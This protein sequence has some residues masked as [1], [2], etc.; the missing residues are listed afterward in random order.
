MVS[1]AVDRSAIPQAPA[2]SGGRSPAEGW[3]SVILHAAL[4][5]VMAGAIGRVDQRER[6]AIL[7][8]L[9]LAGGAAG[10][11]LA[12]T[13]PVDLLAHLTTF[14][15]GV[16]AALGLTAVRCG[17]VGGGWRQSLHRLDLRAERLYRLLQQNK[18]L[19]EDL[20]VAVIGMT[21]WLVAYSSAWMLYRRRWLGPSLMLPGVVI[22]TSLGLDRDA[23]AT[24]IFAYLVLAMVLAARHF[25]FRRQQ[26][27]RRARI[28]APQ[29][30]PNRFL[31]AGTVVAAF[32][33]TIGI[34]LPVQAPDSVLNSVSDRA[35]KTWK[36]LETQWNRYAPGGSGASQGGT[37]ADFPDSFRLGARINLE[38]V[39]VVIFKA[40]A[41][42]YLATRRY[43]IYDGHG[44]STDVD[45]TFRFASDGKDVRATRATFVPAQPVTL[46]PRVTKDRKAETG[47]VQVLRGKDGLV[48]TIDTHSMAS[49]STTVSLGWGKFDDLSIPVDSVDANAVSP[50][51]YRLL[52]LLQNATFAPGPAGGEPTVVQTDRATQI[53]QARESLRLNYPVQ[54]RLELVNGRAVLHIS[55][56]LPVYDDIEAV[57]AGDPAQASGEYLVTG[58]KSQATPQELRQAGVDYPQYVKDRY[59]QLPDTITS[60][61]RELAAHVVSAAHANNPFDEAMALQEYLRSSYTYVLNPT[62]SGNTDDFVDDFLFQTKQGR[63]E[64]YATAMLVMLRTLGVP[65]RWVSGYNSG[66]SEQTPAGYVYYEDQVHSWVEAYFPGYGWIPFEPTPSE[67]EFTYGPDSASAKATPEPIASPLP[68]PTVE[69]TP[70]TTAQPT[71]VAGTTDKPK[72]DTPWYRRLVD[73]LGWLPAAI[74]AVILAATASLAVAWLWGLRGLR[75]AAALYARALRVGRFWGVH[76]DPTMTPAEYASEFARTVPVARSAI[77]AV[78]ETYTEEQ[79]SKREAGNVRLSAARSAWRELRGSVVRWRPWKR[80]RIPA[81]RQEAIGD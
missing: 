16:V 39:P 68:T 43:N 78:A 8:P 33:V 75:P 67:N 57:Y 79:Y 32:A 27:W 42:A 1:T 24:P 58:L 41:P 37:F 73:G 31:P 66:R 65:A 74:S 12:K 7:V 63:C 11:T 17:D 56:R 14:V 3:V 80:G 45:A 49:L 36:R 60:R 69:P 19:D 35:E 15:F 40:S 62:P 52:S 76:S 54:T 23:P 53:Q 47:I 2:R 46:S 44:M 4:L 81:S 55:G 34:L 50:D 22:L 9:A 30:L 26:D 28:A 10:F 29:T 5:A 51:L 21:I 77:R 18:P 6:L 61:T 71:P 38:H 48:F 13:R 20:L 59:L 25:A 72:D 70:T 64:H